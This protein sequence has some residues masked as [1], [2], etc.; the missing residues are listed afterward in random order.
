L[1]CECECPYGAR[2]PR[3]CA[4]LLS[5]ETARA[6]IGRDGSGVEPDRRGREGDP[7]LASE[8]L[9]GGGIVILP[10]RGWG[11]E[12]D[13]GCGGRGG[14]GGSDDIGGREG[15]VGSDGKDGRD[16][17]D[18]SGGRAGKLSGV[19]L[20]NEL[21][22]E[23]GYAITW[24]DAGARLACGVRLTMSTELGLA[25]CVGTGGSLGACCC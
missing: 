18:G 12:R 8:E 15:N 20:G 7:E 19:L 25:L 14:S 4:S 9:R 13:C 3:G 2:G 5:F 21:G 1:V 24:P 6:S 11:S 23:D 10:L 16:G 22:S 17:S